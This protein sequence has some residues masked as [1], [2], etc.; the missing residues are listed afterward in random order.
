MESS[1]KV[2]V[3]EHCENCPSHQWCTRHDE[4]QYKNY[5]ISGRYIE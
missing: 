5:A 1:K 3:I 2:F 4:K